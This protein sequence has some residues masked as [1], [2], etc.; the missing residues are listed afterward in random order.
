MQVYAHLVIDHC[1]GADAQ[2]INPI[3]G[4]SRWTKFA[5][6]SGKFPHDVNSFHPSRCET[7]DGGTFGG[8]PDLCHRNPDV[9]TAV[10]EHAEWLINT[11]G[12]DGFRLDFVK[13]Y[14]GW[15][16]RAIQELRGLHGTATFKPFAVG[17]AG[18]TAA[19]S[20][21]GLAKPMPGRTTRSAPSIFRCAIASATCVR[22]MASAC[23]N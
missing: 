1:S 9:Y 18:T 3:D 8:M 17:E 20:R 15:V 11:I 23:A 10:L 14:G 22:P 4:V 2:E 5:P 21:I 7:W 16:V 6:K 13:G 19:R 12:Y